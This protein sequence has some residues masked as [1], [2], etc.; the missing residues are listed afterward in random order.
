MRCARQGGQPISLSFYTGYGMLGTQQ[1]NK[2]IR[3]FVTASCGSVD[4][5]QGDAASAA[6]TAADIVEVPL[7][8]AR[9]L[10]ASLYVAP[11]LPATS[12]VVPAALQRQSNTTGYLYP[13]LGAES[14]RL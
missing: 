14:P 9:A 10:N 13:C 6:L 4:T 12:I 1:Y 11:L 5:L 2:A 3:V 8:L 7:D